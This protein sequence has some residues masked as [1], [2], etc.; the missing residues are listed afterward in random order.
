[1]LKRNLVANYLGQGWVAL[2]G[3]VF[4]P[5][6]IRYMGIEA[7]GV[8]G[9]FAILQAWLALLDTGLNIPLRREMA[10]FMGSG[11]DSTG[12]R[13]LLRS[14]EMIALVL[15]VLVGGCIHLSST[16][17]ADHWLRADSLPP[18][19]VALAFSCMGA[20]T[21]LRM[22][23]GVYRSCLLGLQRQVE[24]NLVNSAVAT[25][26]A[27][28]AVAVLAWLAPTLQAFFL[29]QALMSLASLALLWRLTQSA[30]PPAPRRA[31][32]SVLRLREI[33][34]F[35]G[36]T[37]SVTLLGLMLTQIDK[38]LL[39][40]LLPL[41]DFGQYTL[42]A[43]VAGALYVLSSPVTQA[44]FPRL[45]QLHASGDTTGL[46]RAF[47]QG[48]QAVS[49]V[50]G[51]AGVVLI[52]FSEPFLRLWTGDPALARQVS[53][54]LEL[55][56]AGTVLNATI[57]MPYQAQLAHGW[58]GLAV[59]INMIAVLL[60]IPGLLWATPRF[61]AVGAAGVW[62]VL[63]AGYV[64]VMPYFMHRRILAGEKLRWYVHDLLLPIG[65]AAGMTFLVKFAL[66][67]SANRAEELAAMAAASMASICAAVLASAQLRHH[68]LALLPRGIRFPS[69]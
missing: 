27:V 15:A 39:S 44:V 18:S 56:V 46:A 55:L 17:L 11:G 60:I 8:I 42:A 26:R 12:I 21:A 69:A 65:A 1:M 22:V 67:G 66:P 64:L 61:G 4:V 24:F 41:A 33:G 28:G 34:M 45:S 43:V 29:W 58:G 25:F 10:G 49:V 62:V 52:A 31:M 38:V 68:A 35:A 57:G 23:E 7:Y 51:S 5:I 40:R 48:A 30:L 63:N 50:L 3:F 53:P 47:H 54:V 19:D 2:M 6:Y 13:D 36:S 32:F 37:M 16:W 59:R 20:V 9:L 14:I